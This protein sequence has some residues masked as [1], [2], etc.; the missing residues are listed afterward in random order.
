MISLYGPDHSF[1]PIRVQWLPSADTSSYPFP[2][3]CGPWLGCLPAAK[4]SK[5]HF[6]TSHMGG[7]VPFSKGPFSKAPF[8]KRLLVELF[9]KAAS[10]KWLSRLED[11]LFSRPPPAR[12]PKNDLGKDLGLGN[13]HLSSCS[14]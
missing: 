12:G 4:A 6:S 1:I 3:A 10:R 8:F 9:G 11:I 2:R 14:G 5:L 13:D 7:Y